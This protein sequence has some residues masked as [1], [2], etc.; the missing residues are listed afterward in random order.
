M[1]RIDVEFH[2]F[3]C[4]IGRDDKRRIVKEK[5]LKKE[6]C[7]KNRKNDFLDKLEI[8]TS[9]RIRRSV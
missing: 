8:N 6:F 3:H 7:L 9:K 5:L 2:G 4:I 1:Q